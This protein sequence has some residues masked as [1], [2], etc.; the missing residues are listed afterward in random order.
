MTST[1]TRIM[2]IFDIYILKNL[3]LATLFIALV[4]TFIIFLTQSLRFLEIVINAGSSGNAFWI[5]TSLALPRFFEV[6]LPLSIMASTLFLYNKMSVDSELIAMRATGYSSFSLATPAIILGLGITVIL[7]VTTMWIAPKSLAQMQTMRTALKTEFSNFLFKEGVFNAVGN[8]LTVYIREKAE[9][10]TLSGMMIHDTRESNT[11]PTTI[12]AKRGIMIANE[13]GHQVIV[14]DGS[15]QSFNPKSGILQ[16]LA[17]DQYTIDLPEN[18][19]AR[20]RWAEPDERTIFELLN[21]DP[22]NPRDVESTR[23]FNVEIHR[24]ITGP[25]LALAFPLIALSIFLL[26]PTDRRGQSKRIGL[27]IFA[28]MVVQGIYLATFNMARN[29]DSGIILMYILPITPIGV[30]LFALS[31]YSVN[32]RRKFLYPQKGG[33]P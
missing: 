13:D 33:T 25:L 11:P 2:K 3:L 14:F 30:S 28:T 18:G 32:L 19:P 29:H 21:P 22:N 16:K 20:K 17:F 7:W 23:E 26:G 10:G 4:L 12:L 24:R 15:R 8:G 31:S 6:I 5:L 9:D 1:N 27:A